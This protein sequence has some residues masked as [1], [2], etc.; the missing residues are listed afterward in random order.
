MDC[1]LINLDTAVDRLAHMSAQLT[2][3]GVVVTR[4][5]AVEAGRITDEELAHWR[6]LNRIWQPVTRTEIAC[7]LSHRDVWRR[8]VDSGQPWALVIEDDLHL[9]DGLVRFLGKSDWIPS[10]A[11]VVRAETDYLPVELSGVAGSAFGHN[12]RRM[13]SDQFGSAGYFLS[14]DAACKLLHLTEDCCEPLDC[15]LFSFRG[16]VASRLTSYQLDPALCVQD[17]RLSETAGGKGFASQIEVGK[18][19]E[20]PRGPANP[21]LADKV[22]RELLRLRGQ[23]W[24]AW[25]TASGKSVFKVV[26]IRFGSR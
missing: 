22:V 3:L 19:T 4:V 12:L 17:C 6:A 21:T 14:R 5:A 7:F 18:L 20:R 13:K 25:L 23:A 1:Y 15:L 11:E 26:P 16:S 10:D 9:A 8:I 2:R 24:R